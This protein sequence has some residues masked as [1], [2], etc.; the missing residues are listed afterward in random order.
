[1]LFITFQKPIEFLKIKN[2]SCHSLSEKK[3]FHDQTVMYCLNSL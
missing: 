3:H 1:M 2:A